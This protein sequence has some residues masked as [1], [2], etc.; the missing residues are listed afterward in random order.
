M[1]IRDRYGSNNGSGVGGGGSKMSSSGHDKDD[2]YINLVR[3]NDQIKVTLRSLEDTN[4]VNTVTIR[5]LRAK[6]SRYDVPTSSRGGDGAATRHMDT[7]GMEPQIMRRQIYDLEEQLLSISEQLW[8]ANQQMHDMK[9]DA[10]K[11]PIKEK[12]T[13]NEDAAGNFQQN[14]YMKA[15]LLKLLCS[16]NTEVKSSLMP[17]LATLFKMNSEELRAVYTANPSWVK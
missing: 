6:L 7:T 4:N 8:R 11:K 13:A 9:A 14:A 3:E 17:V 12:T 1:C 10:A 5:D 2:A 15:I 16:Q